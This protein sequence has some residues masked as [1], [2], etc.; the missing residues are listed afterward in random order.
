M[1][2]QRPISRRLAAADRR[3]RTY[4]G[5]PG[6]AV[7]AADVLVFAVVVPLAVRATD[8]ATVLLILAVVVLAVVVARRLRR[9]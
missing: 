7:I 2:E 1:T 9:R 3:V 4:L 8:T 5:G 6:L